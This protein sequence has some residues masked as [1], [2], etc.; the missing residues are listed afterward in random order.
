MLGVTFGLLGALAVAERPRSP[1]SWLF[2]AER[3]DQST[4]RDALDIMRVVD[5]RTHRPGS[6]DLASYYIYDKPLLAPADG[7]VTFLMDGPPDP[8]DRA[9]RQPS[10]RRRRC[11]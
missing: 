7:V 11:R 10:P 2:V 1:L 5:G 9:G 4:Q 6:T 8:A 3:S